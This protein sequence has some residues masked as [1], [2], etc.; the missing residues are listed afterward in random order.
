MEI[1]V[2][3]GAWN[4]IPTQPLT[5]SCRSPA[6]APT[7]TSSLALSFLAEE[8][9]HVGDSALALGIARYP[10]PLRAPPFRARA[11][12]QFNCRKWISLVVI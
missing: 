6:T 12:A 10:E 1:A 4:Q 8:S 9:Q 2:H 3:D 7:P 11:L 5:K